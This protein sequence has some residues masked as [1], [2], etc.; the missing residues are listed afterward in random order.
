MGVW[1]GDSGFKSKYCETRWGLG[2][3]KS[4][5]RKKLQLGRGGGEKKLK[6]KETVGH[7]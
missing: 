3:R 2:E 1:E 7:G 5:R 6:P 4:K